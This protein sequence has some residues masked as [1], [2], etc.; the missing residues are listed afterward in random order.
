MTNKKCSQRKYFFGSVSEK[1]RQ[2]NR[3]VSK[4]LSSEGNEIK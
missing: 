1:N 4:H 3:D 2:K